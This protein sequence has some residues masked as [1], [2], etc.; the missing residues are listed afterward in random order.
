ALNLSG[1]FDGVVWLG[2]TPFWAF[3]V[4]PRSVCQLSLVAMRLP[5][6][7]YKLRPGSGSAPETPTPASDG[8][9]ARS[10]TVLGPFLAMMKPLIRT[11]S[12]LETV[13]RVERLSASGPTAGNLVFSR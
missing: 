3:F 6:E 4:E 1:W 2:A 12:P 8:P 7:L 10:I 13:P 5:D 11:S 9:S